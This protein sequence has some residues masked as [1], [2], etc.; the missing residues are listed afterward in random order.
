M[1]KKRLILWIAVILTLAFI[2]GQSLLNQEAS[3]KESNV[4]KEK[5]VQPIH[6]AVTGNSSLP[7]DI[8]DIAHIVEFLVLGLELLLLLKNKKIPIRL[9]RTISYC[10]FVALIDESIQ[11]FSG[12]APQVVDIWYDIIGSAIGAFI[13]VLAILVVN[14]LRKPKEQGSVNPTE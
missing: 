6:E 4:V 2:F 12:R 11:Y 8:R 9:L 1:E 14:G 3:V 10:G 7:H 5:V 13:G